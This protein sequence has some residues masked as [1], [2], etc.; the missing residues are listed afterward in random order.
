MEFEKFL[1]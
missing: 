1:V